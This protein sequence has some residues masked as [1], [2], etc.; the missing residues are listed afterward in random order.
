MKALPGRHRTAPTP[1]TIHPRPAP[2]IG[3]RRP[4]RVLALVLVGRLAFELPRMS[5]GNP[6][7]C[8]VALVALTVAAVVACRSRT[9]TP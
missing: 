5:K 1:D 7:V 6:A 9:A 4:P 3:Q 8:V 2:S